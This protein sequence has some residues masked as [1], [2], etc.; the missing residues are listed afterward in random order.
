VPVESILL[1]LWV[2]S[3]GSDPQLRGVARHFG[4]N[5]ETVFHSAEE[6]VI[7]LQGQIARG[8]DSGHERADD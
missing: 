1:R 5:N 8:A 3:P 6:L 7:W 2:P 4:S